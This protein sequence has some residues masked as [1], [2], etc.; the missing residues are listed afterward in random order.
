MEIKG[1][2]TY[3][4]AYYLDDEQGWAYDIRGADMQEI[5]PLLYADHER[6]PEIVEWIIFHGVEED[7]GGTFN[8]NPEPPGVITPKELGYYK[9]KYEHEYFTITK[10]EEYF[11]WKM[12]S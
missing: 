10:N 3:S 1:M 8:D 6:Y 4:E 9:E 2:K 5:I 12:R 11:A 7:G